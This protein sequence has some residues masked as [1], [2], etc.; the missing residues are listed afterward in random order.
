METREAFF[1]Y[2]MHDTRASIMV[3]ARIRHLMNCHFIF[4]VVAISTPTKVHTEVLSN[5]D[6]YFLFGESSSAESAVLLVHN[7]IVQLSA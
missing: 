6:P 2:S 4:G 5:V 3:L 1:S 7:D